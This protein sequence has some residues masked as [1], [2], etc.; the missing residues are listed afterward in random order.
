VRVPC[1][2]AQIVIDEDY[3]IMMLIPGSSLQRVV[4]LTRADKQNILEKLRDP[5]EDFPE[6]EPML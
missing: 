2:L 4:R 1:L 6:L 3:F 5:K